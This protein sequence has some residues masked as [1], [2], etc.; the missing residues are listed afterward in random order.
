MTAEVLHATRIL[1]SPGQVVEVRAI[2]DDGMASGYFN[3]AEELAAKVEVLDGLHTVQGMYGTLNPVNPALFSRRANRI[4]VRLGKKDATTADIDIVC[5]RWFPVDIDPVRPSGVSS[6]DAEHATAL[7]KARSVAEFLVGKGFPAPVLADSG[8]GAHLLYRVDLPN[9]E[10]EKA[11]VKRCLD[12][13][14]AI[15]D[16]KHATIDTANYNA[17]RIWKLYGTMSRKGDNTTDRPHRR[18]AII[19]SP[20]VPAIVEREVL[21]LLAKTLPDDPSPPV[22]NGHTGKTLD[23]RQWLSLHGIGVQAEKPWQGGTISILDECPFS[24]NHKDGAFTIQ[25]PSGAIYAGCHHQSCGGGSQRWQELRERYEPVV[26]RKSEACQKEYPKAAP[27]R[28]PPEPSPVLV[29]V[30]LSHNAEALEILQHGNPKKV[31]LETFLLDHVGDEI[32][33]ECLIMSFASRSV[34]N[35]K[36]LHVSVTGETGKGKSVTFDTFLL[37]VPERFKLVGAMSNKA[38]YYIE[39]LMPGTAIVF[40]DKTLSDDMQEILKSATSTF[41]KPIDY[42]TVNKD[43]KPIVCTIPERCVWWM[44]KVEGAGDDQVFNRMLTCWIDESCEQDDRVL[45]RV[46]GENAELPVS[47]MQE[48]REVLICRTMWEIIGKERFG[49]VIPFAR[50]IRFQTNSNRRNPE[51]LLD[52]VKANALMHFMQRKRQESNGSTFLLATREDFDAAVRL[53]SMLNGITGGQTTKLTKKEFDLL[54]TIE[55]SRWAEFTI[56]MLQKVTGLPNGNVHKIIHGFINKGASYSGLLEKCPAIAYTDRTIIADDDICG[57]STRR[58]TNA[59]TFDRDLYRQ[60]CAGGSVWLDNDPDPDAGNTSILPHDFH[61]TSTGIEVFKNAKMNPDPEITGNYTHLDISNTQDFHKPDH[62]ENRDM[63]T[64]HASSCACEP[65]IIE[66]LNAKT[67]QKYQNSEPAAQ[68]PP[69]TLQHVQ[70]CME[71]QNTKTAQ[72]PQNNEPAPQTPESGL[73]QITGNMEGHLE[74]TN[75][76]REHP[77]PIHATEYKPLD[78]PEPH[79]PCFVCGKKG[80][81]YGE[82][83]TTERRARP[84]DKQIARRVCRKCYDAVVRKDRAAAPPLPGVIDLLGME[85]HAPD[86][87]K[88]SVCNLKAATYLNKESGVKLCEHCHD[89]EVHRQCG[90]PK[91]QA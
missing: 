18:S 56:P 91:V 28:F 43:R 60:W 13:L 67:V 6:T 80:S 41:R 8:N 40:D 27:P 19:S 71:G 73:P 81:W 55:R 21:K 3:S 64:A 39:N 31:M 2:T 37:Q 65:G 46:L 32:V 58:R 68:N 49:V 9:D 15:F 86:I 54:T 62:T 89:R 1:F 77:L 10:A 23:L 26:E 29:S 83:L 35:T 34:E 50:R 42:R 33:A 88:C 45:T 7:A 16:D 59:Y 36:G 70:K 57:V 12:V 74:N 61:N 14:A 47:G 82:K 75:G 5:R 24:G 30:E 44:A 11:L 51:M 78:V 25:F 63:E 20:A 76:I 85:R 69:I 90:N 48:R 22:R 79:I 66:V 52:L 17:A 4:K 38:L 53:Y 72:Q 87:G 84:K